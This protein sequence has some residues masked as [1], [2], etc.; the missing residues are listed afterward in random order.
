MKKRYTYNR[1]SGTDIV[2]NESMRGVVE[3]L[4]WACASTQAA[5]PTPDAP[6][7]I[8]SS[9]DGGKIVMW[10]HKKN[11]LNLGT[12]NSINAGLLNANIT[13]SLITITGSTNG[14][15]QYIKLTGTQAGA[16]APLPTAWYNDTF[17]KSGTYTMSFAN[18][19]II[20]YTNGSL[21]FRAYYKDGTNSALL[22]ENNTLTITTTKDIAFLALVSGV[23]S[24]Y[25][26]SFNLQIEQ[27]S[28]A[29]TYEPYTGSTTDITTPVGYIGG[30]LPNGVADSDTQKKIGKVV[31]N[32]S[33]SW[34][35]FESTNTNTISFLYAITD[36][37]SSY[38]SGQTNMLC[39]KFKANNQTYCLTH[40]EE[41][42]CFR[43]EG[44]KN[45]FFSILKSRLTA[46]T[47]A[48][49]KT[50]LSTNNA[51]VYYELATPETI[52]IT[53]PPVSTYEGINTITTTNNVKP[54]LTIEAW[55][56]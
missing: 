18:K 15:G 9:G 20:N 22:V 52:T 10:S 12:N 1:L 40:K 4:N 50:W 56:R 48:A 41:E 14:A 5:N 31:L 28:S 2:V 49:F 45:Y 35:L 8:Y 37:S 38:V 16:I 6:K 39:D 51:T 11:M 30:S 3:K 23:V 54:S 55:K 13:G 46:N 36:A 26:L 53:K 21:S 27:N 32:G 19:T 42:W 29:T 17:L 7:P 34:S 47:V 25:N 33:E 43:N 44:Y 24:T